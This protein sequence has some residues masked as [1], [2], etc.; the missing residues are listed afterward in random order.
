MF[1]A[2]FYC[3]LN[4]NSKTD[5]IIELES[6][7]KWL[8]FSRKDPAKRVLEKHFKQDIDYKIHKI[9]EKAA[10]QDPRQNVSC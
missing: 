10:P 7:W 3:Y 9:E 8:G 4:H 6:I 2:S 1:I 5:F